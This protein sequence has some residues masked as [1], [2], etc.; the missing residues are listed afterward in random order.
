MKM[1]A[2]SVKFL[3]VLYNSI[4]LFSVFSATTDNVHEATPNVTG[5]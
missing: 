3:L 2:R 4:A 5:K 1:S